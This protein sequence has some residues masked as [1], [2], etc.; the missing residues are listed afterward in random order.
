MVQLFEYTFLD[1][2]LEQH[3]SKPKL[4]KEIVVFYREEYCWVI[5]NV[6]TIILLPT[7]KFKIFKI[8]SLEHNVS[9]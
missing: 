7:D 1:F 6:E 3:H 2:I 4:N 5:P 9:F 8:F